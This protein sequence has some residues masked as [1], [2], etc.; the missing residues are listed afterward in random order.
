MI[1]DKN[2]EFKREYVDEIKKTLIAF[3]NTEGGSLYIGIADNGEPLGIEDADD[4]VL[5]IGNVIRDAIRPDLT[6]FCDIAAENLQGKTVVKVAVN[7]GMARPYYLASKGIRPE[8]VYIRLGTA[9]VPASESMILSMIRETAGDSYE[10]AR[11]LVQDLTFREAETVFD[12]K[13]ISFGET[14]KRKARL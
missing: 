12:D 3:A 8:G 13:G 10:E 14:Q 6:M 4:V 11:S 1:E 9:S 5:R 7:R 2:T